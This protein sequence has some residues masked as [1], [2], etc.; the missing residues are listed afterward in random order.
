MSQRHGLPPHWNRPNGNAVTSDDKSTFAPLLSVD[1]TIN[2]SESAALKAPWNFG[3]LMP[4]A[5]A[6]VCRNRF[7]AKLAEHTGKSRS[8]LKHRQQ[9]AER[10]PTETELADALAKDL[11]HQ[12]ERGRFRPGEA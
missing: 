7:L 2:G 3:Q 10:Y 5:V 6:A 9:F 11:A 8:E 4:A 12:P 1:L